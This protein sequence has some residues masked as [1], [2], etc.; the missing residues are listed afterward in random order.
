MKNI[1]FTIWY[2]L[3]WEIRLWKRGP[4]FFNYDISVPT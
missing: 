2:D 1:F 4:F 3:V